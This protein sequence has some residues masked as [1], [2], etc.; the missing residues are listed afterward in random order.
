[1]Q[2]KLIKQ[3][4]SG[5]TLYLPKKWVDKH[6]LNTGD[7]VDIE[8]SEDKLVIAAQIGKCVPRLIE[9]EIPQKRESVVRTILVNAY[10]AG[11]DKFIVTYKGNP[12]ELNSIV[13]DNLIGFEVFKKKEATFSLESV[14]EPSYGSWENIIEKQFYIIG[15]I[16]SLLAREDCSGLGLKVQRYDNFLKR[17][18]S[19][20]VFTTKA[21]PFLWQFLSNLTQ[22]ARQG[23]HF[24]QLLM[25][26]KQKLSPKEQHFL[27]EIQK[28]FA[29]LQK[30][31]LAKNSEVLVE[32]HELEQ[33][34]LRDQGMKLLQTQNPVHLHYLVTLGR[35]IY[36]ANSPLEGYL[37]VSSHSTAAS[38]T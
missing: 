12:Q 2:R 20:G 33:K 11:Y 8:E 27:E 30:A 28:M 21:M 35:L 15:E 32:L 7:L 18:I 17:C 36:L 10:R 19:K 25:K 26:N 16:F 31:Y 37:Q 3:G 29:T 5:L 34:L 4:G 23:Y 14:A 24:N 13:A 22:I 1:M 9:L 6:H 38:R